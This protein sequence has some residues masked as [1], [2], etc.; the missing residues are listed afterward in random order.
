M[1]TVQFNQKIAQGQIIYL[2]PLLSL[3]L[4]PNSLIVFGFLWKTILIIWKSGSSGSCCV[5]FFLCLFP[6]QSSLDV[7][8]VVLFS[9]WCETSVSYYSGPSLYIL[10]NLSFLTVLMFQHHS[11]MKSWIPLSSC[12]CVR[13]GTLK[14][15]FINV[16]AFIK[17]SRK[18]KSLMKKNSNV[19]HLK[20]KLQHNKVWDLEPLYEGVLIR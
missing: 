5:L 20:L 16:C 19:I 9:E 7:G 12:C 13:S 15:V 8:F 3:P 10:S 6:S 2:F 4:S 1:L 14:H 18:L 11:H 17:E